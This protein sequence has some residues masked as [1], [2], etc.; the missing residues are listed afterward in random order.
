[1]VVPR[2]IMRICI[3][4]NTPIPTNTSMERAVAD[5]VDCKLV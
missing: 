5:C 4:C 3:V 2:I 1:M